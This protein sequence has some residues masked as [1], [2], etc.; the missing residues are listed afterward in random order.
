MQ[1]YIPS[2]L[3]CIQLEEED[4]AADQ[5]RR[6]PP[7]PPP[8]LLALRG[9]REEA[10]GSA[11]SVEAGEL[12]SSGGGGGAGAC[13][14]HAAGRSRGGARAAG[15][16][17]SGPPSSLAGATHSLAGAPPILLLPPLSAATS[18]GHPPPLSAATS[19]GLELT[20]QAEAR[21]WRAE[22][23][24]RAAL[25]RLELDLRRRPHASRAQPAPVAC[26]ASSGSARACLLYTSPSPRDS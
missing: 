25:T 3:E 2:L 6:R 18:V 15:R 13:E 5:R 10:A 14:L 19:A 20:G 4:A 1:K 24:A 26:G 21:A 7:R 22:P 8:V 23:R 16:N 9:F 11:A 17:G 12:G